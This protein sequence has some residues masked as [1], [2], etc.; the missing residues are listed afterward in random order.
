MRPDKDTFERKVFRSSRLAEFASVNELIRQTGQPVENWPLV[1]AKELAD[2]ALD[3]AEKAGT[4]PMV[5]IVT[6]D[7]SITVVDHGPGIAP[8]VV[9]S[10]TDYAFKTSSN[11]AY[12]SPSRGQQGNA[13]QSIIPM[14]FALANAGDNQGRDHD[15][16]AVDT[17]TAVSIESQGFAHHIGFSVDPVRQTPRVSHLKERSAVKN[18]ARITVRWPER[19]RSLITDAKDRFLSL[20]AI[21]ILL[22]PH[23]TLSAG[24]NWRATDLGWKKWRPSQPT[25]AYWYDDERL[26]RLMAA[27]IADAEDR[28]VACPSVRDFIGQFRG[29][30]GTAKQNDICVSL[31]VAERLSLADFYQ[32][33]GAAAA[34]PLL[35]AIRLRSQTVKPRDLGVIGGDHLQARFVAGGADP[36]TFVYRCAAFEHDGLPNV[37]EAA[38]AYR[39]CKGE[40]DGVGLRVVEGF[41]FSP[42]VG[43]SPFNLGELLASAYVEKDDPVIVFAHLTSP[44]LNFRDRGKTRVDLPP[45]V[46]GKITDLVTAVAKKWTKQKKAEIR[47]DE[48]YWRR[49]DALA[50]R[51]TVKINEAAYAVME[52]SYLTASADGKGGA[53]PCKPRQIMYVARPHI[54][55]RT[56]RQTFDDG[57]FTQE[58]LVFFMR[59]NPELTAD[60]DIIWDDR[61]HFAEPHTDVGIGLGTLPVRDY[62][63]GFHRAMIEPARIADAYVSTR[64]PEGR[65]HAVLFCEKE[66]FEPIFQAAGIYERYDLAPMST[67]GMSTTAGRTLVEELCGKRGLPLFTLH[68]FDSYGFGINEND[69][70]H[71][72]L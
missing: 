49:E 23:L 69:Q 40:T 1:I 9:A 15:S 63:K 56:G 71:R 3:A 64:G 21:Y 36:E 27:M 39:S 66:G 5:E 20:A 55:K 48:A 57:Y 31:G 41:N 46:A 37:I 29:L 35:E 65:Y 13:L 4:A 62:I 30:S 11:A 32:R 19:A 45:A 8:A 16:S 72:A 47:S 2:N 6:A 67:K 28:R 70:R 12:V 26:T 60:W 18:G 43:G 61:G 54:L 14:G 25:S 38:F 22:N 59:D 34:S 7:N 51:D 44:R 52:A 17:G 58:L 10:L 50:W 33:R 68:D 42:A 24:S 53:L